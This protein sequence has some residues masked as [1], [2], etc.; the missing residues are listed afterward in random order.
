MECEVNLDPTRV[1]EMLLSWKHLQLTSCTT[2]QTLWS[3]YG[4]ICHVTARP[5]PGAEEWTAQNLDPYCPRNTSGD[6]PLILKIV[7][8]PRAGRQQESEGHLRKMLS[9]EVEQFFYYMVAPLLP[10]DVPVARYVCSTRDRDHLPPELVGVLATIITD[11]R[12]L[13]PVSPG[14]GDAL[15]SLGVHAAID[16]LA[17]F[18]GE[19][20]KYL[21]I[22]IDDFILPPLEEARHRGEFGPRSNLWRN[23]GYTYLATRRQEY[24]NL[25][26]DEDS[27]WSDKLCCPIEGSKSVAELVAD[28]LAPRGRRFEVFVHGDVKSEN[29]ATDVAGGHVALFDFQY[30]GLSLGVC[31]LAK[32]LTCSVPLGQILG[33]DAGDDAA[34]GAQLEYS[35]AMCEGERELL[36][37]YWSRLKRFGD[38]KGVY[39]SWELFVRHW[40]AALVDWLRFQASWGFWGNT[41]WLE[42]R[43]RSILQ[44]QSWWDWLDKANEH[45]GSCP[46]DLGGNRRDDKNDSAEA[47]DVDAASR[48]NGSGGN[49][50]HHDGGVS[51]PR[52]GAGV[53]GKMNRDAM[54]EAVRRRDGTGRRQQQ[55]HW[56]HQ[57]HDQNQYQNQ[58]A[59]SP[60]RKPY[61]YLVSD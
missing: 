8:P 49:H 36:W 16:W 55:R 59:E 20:Y 3:G 22:G 7:V 40:E 11:L 32:L 28:F 6:Y 58:T 51:G 57:N 2:F 27:E 52:G 53:G 18:H 45:D 17:R 4:F 29:M 21:P 43:V 19:S 25:E 23:G 24:V 33:G 26:Q 1:A 34:A 46:D 15:S 56:Q 35:M 60:V 39:Y 47:M 5:N 54:M 31:D 44:D 61:H 14:K 48:L 13:Y 42:A 9:Y 37:R 38:A 41:R 10:D 50:H 12:P 30:I